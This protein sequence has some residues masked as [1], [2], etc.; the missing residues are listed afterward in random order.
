MSICDLGMGS[1]VKT[2][3]IEVD[4]NETHPLIMLANTLPWP[5]LYELIL[6]DLKNTTKKGFWYLGRKIKVRIHLAAFIL[7]LFYNLSD[8]QT[9]Y[10]IKDNAA[11]KVFCGFGIVD[12]WNAPDHTKIEKFRSRLSPETQRLIG[13]K[14]VQHAV[15]LGIADPKD[16]DVDST[17]QE[18]NMTYPTDAKML[19][20]LVTLASKVSEALKDI[21]AEPALPVFDLKDIAL[22]ARNCFFQKRYATAEEKSENL[23]ALWNAVN[24]SVRQ[25]IEVCNSLCQEEVAKLKWN[26]KRSM[27]QIVSQGEDYLTES[28][29]FIDTGKATK[30]KKLSFHLNEVECFSKGKAHKKHEFGRAFQLARIG[31]N[32]LITAACTT[33]RMDDKKSIEPIIAEHEKL[34]GSG[35]I[36]TL[37][38]DKGYYSNKNVKHAIDKGIDKVGI[39]APN[40]IVN[41][42][43]N[44]SVGDKEILYNRRSGIEPLI[45]HAKQGGQLGRS[46]MKSDKTIKASGYASVIGFNL[47]QLVRAQKK[48]RKDKVAA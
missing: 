26:I 43:A 10:G 33:I 37:S 31:G 25:T 16:V 38:T 44:L 9:E 21:I 5:D 22:K 46:R 24:Q 15:S 41:D 8:R 13:N 30:D 47:R 20:K 6:P 39:Q 27:N 42:V 48:A 36:E 34:F 19:R 12:K 7:Q 1:K 40:S 28:K 17:V 4:V 45:G 18:A 14:V 11:Y 3:K 23:E 35:K 32:F 29:I 2:G